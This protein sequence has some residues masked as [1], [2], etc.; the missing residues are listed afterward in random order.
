MKKRYRFNYPHY[1]TPDCLPDYTAHRGSVVRIVRQLDPSEV[2]EQCGA[3]YE[4][5][6][7][8]GWIGTAD[9]TELEPL[10]EAGDR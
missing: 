10:D 8:D 2:D 1:G 7:E 3:V 5:Q 6:A 4:V 9:A